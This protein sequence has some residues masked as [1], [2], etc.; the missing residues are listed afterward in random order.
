LEKSLGADGTEIKS[1]G[2]DEVEVE[3]GEG[4]D[5]KVGLVRLAKIHGLDTVLFKQKDTAYYHSH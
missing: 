5:E 4:Q 3:E 2:E 1:G